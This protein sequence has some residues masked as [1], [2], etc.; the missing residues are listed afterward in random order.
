MAAETGV[1]AAKARVFGSKSRWIS[2]VSVSLLFGVLACRSEPPS[3]AVE[4]TAAPEDVAGPVDP[5]A[6]SAQGAWFQN[7]P[8]AYGMRL[9]ARGDHAGA[10]AAFGEFLSAPTNDEDEAMAKVLSGLSLHALG[11][12]QEEAEA[13]AAARQ[14]PSTAA[15]SAQLRVLEAQAQLD[16]GDPKAAEETLQGL[17]QGQGVGPEL[18]LV[19][20]DALLR[21]DRSGEAIEAYRAYLGAAPATRRAHE[22]RA[23]LARA[24]ESRAKDADGD[25]ESAESDAMEAAKLWDRLSLDVPASEYGREAMRVLRAGAEARLGRSAKEQKNQ[26]LA[27]E[28]GT[29]R[30]QLKRRQY[31]TVIAAA[32]KAGKRSGLSTSAKCEFAFIE[33]SA[34][35]KQRKRA[36][37]RPVFERAAPL[38]KKAHA[39]DL[40]VK[41]R[42]QG[43]R[44]RYAEGQFTKAARA[45]EALA[46]DHAD[47]TYADDAW[48]KAGE[49]WESGGKNKAARRA[50]RKALSE[51]PEGDMREEARRRLMLMA[52]EDADRHS[53]VSELKV[54]LK[55]PDVGSD[56]RARLEYFLGRAKARGG[57]MGT[58]V[59]A[60]YLEVL[61]LRPIS[62]AGLQALSRLKELGP[63]SFEAGL[64]LVQAPPEA[65]P[66]LELPGRDVMGEERARLWARLGAGDRAWEALQELGVRGWPAVALLGEAQ[67][68]PEAQRRLADLGTAWRSHSPSETTRSHWELAHPRPF[69]DLI[70]GGE[71][72]HGV[73]DLLTF[74]IMQT[75]SRFD[76]DVTSW[77]GARGLIQLMPATA[78][79]LASRAGIT[80]ASGDLYRPDV[81]L[82]L[83]MRYLARLSAR[84]GGSAGAA[85]L[86]APSYNAGAGAVDR[87]VDADPDQDLDLFIESIPYKETRRYARS[88][89]GR[90]FAYRWLYGSDD[91]AL[92]IP[93]LPKKIPA[94]K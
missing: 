2:S 86:A 33:G 73:P 57:A 70:E 42:Y 54:F 88:V 19:R 49:S 74:A 94:R 31:E 63:A 9:Q 77:A 4:S 62:Y 12:Y 50:Y 79:D 91:P 39:K 78:K 1:F 8:A 87:W 35:F 89:M 10:V 92:R 44:G 58:Q 6:R 5:I 56:E 13:F 65:L 25:R 45:F 53:A 17:A 40:E 69:R 48:I 85:S 59:E 26:V 47:H 46:L 3:L 80:L 28:L 61:R 41:S 37:S 32:K 43:A 76:P 14:D 51:H 75:E 18:E 84:R 72:K 64:A 16:A 7:G 68:W 66:A 83:G 67:A 60:H 81:N 30:T 11:R 71:R 15:I 82:D 21:L 52:F 29:L 55:S 22:A 20:A 27:R 36:A 34:I 90:W 23:K 24:L 38:C 93:L